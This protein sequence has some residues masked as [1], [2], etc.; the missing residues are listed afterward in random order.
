MTAPDIPCLRVTEHTP[1]PHGYV[2][3][4][5][6]FE[7]MARTHRQT[8]CPGC[9]LFTI[10][11]PLPD[12]PVLPPIAHRLDHAG[13]GCCNGDQEGCDCLYHPGALRAVATRRWHARKH[14]K[15][16]AGGRR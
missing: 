2:A 4:Q 5:L 11:E 7:Q 15:T 1:V 10:W 9:G 13:C 16:A 12:A 6:W 8:R 14:T 3:R